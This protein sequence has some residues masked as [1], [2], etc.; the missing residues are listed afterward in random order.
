MLCSRKQLWVC[1]EGS[2]KLIW[3]VCE[4]NAFEIMISLS[5]TEYWE[6]SIWSLFE[7]A[8]FPFVRYAVA[9]QL[10]KQSSYSTFRNGLWKPISCDVKKSSRERLSLMFGYTVSTWLVGC[11]RNWRTMRTGIIRCASSRAFADA[12]SCSNSRLFAVRQ[13]DRL[14]SLVTLN[15]VVEIQA[16]SECEFWFE[17]I[18]E[19]MLFVK[20]SALKHEPRIVRVW[21]RCD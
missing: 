9:G 10:A 7:Q 17:P 5:L 2:K 19:K 4:N 13:F 6:W 21:V 16:F 15:C 18:T 11:H 14:I 12:L 1:H 20:S 8:D 3:D